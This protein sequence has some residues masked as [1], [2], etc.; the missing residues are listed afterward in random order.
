MAPSPQPHCVS[1]Y[2]VGDVQPAT[3]PLGATRCLQRCACVRCARLKA[4]HSAALASATLP[5]AS[6]VDLLLL[7]RVCSMRASH[8]HRMRTQRRASCTSTRTA[9]TPRSMAMAAASG[10][11]CRLPPSPS[12]PPSQKDTSSSCFAWPL[13]RV[14]VSP[15]R[16]PVCLFRLADSRPEVARRL[17]WNL[18]SPLLT[19]LLWRPSVFYTPAPRED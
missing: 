15:R 1:A 16:S 19:V 10:R 2:F 5:V 14:P 13:I 7:L 9:T 8:P 6:L 18:G 3:F 17:L 12:S 11:R 4:L